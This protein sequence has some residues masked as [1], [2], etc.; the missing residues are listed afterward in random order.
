MYFRGAAIMLMRNLEN[1]LEDHIEGFFNKKFS[2]DLQMIELKK[3]LEKKMQQMKQIEGDITYIPN[4]YVIHMSDPDYQKMCAKDASESLYL[5]IISLAI[6]HNFLI[7]GSLLLHLTAETQVKRGCLTIEATFVENV[8]SENQIIEPDTEL[9]QTKIFNKNFCLDSLK[10]KSNHKIAV[11]RIIAGTDTK[12]HLDIGEK[13]INMGRR[14]SNELLLSDINS[15]RLH[16]YILFEQYRHVVYDADS[17]NGTY[18]NG[19]KIDSYR[20]N[21]GDKIKIGNTVIS[22]E[23][24]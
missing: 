10:P 22:Y 16:A 11:L 13:R 9:A 3:H 18:V 6:K 5:Y 14:E 24:E 1:F 15:S 20:L 2:S 12:I 7:R 23:V 19:N 8:A 21:H 4:T 17:L